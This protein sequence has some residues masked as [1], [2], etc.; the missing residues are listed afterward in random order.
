V[1]TATDRRQQPESTKILREYDI[2]QKCQAKPSGQEERRVAAS[3]E[4]INEP[5]SI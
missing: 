5:S 2:L 1:V 3:A 4:D